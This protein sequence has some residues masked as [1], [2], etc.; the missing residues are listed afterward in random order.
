MKKQEP[1]SD[2]LKDKQSGCGRVFAGLFGLTFMVMG[3]C[4]FYFN[5]LKPYLQKRQSINWPTAE[6]TILEADKETHSGEDSDSY[7]VDFQYTFKVDGQAYSGRRYSFADSNGSLS[8]AERQIATFPVGST[9]KCF[10]NPQDPND[11]VLDRENKDQ[12]WAPFTLPFIFVG[13]GSL[14]LFFVIFLPRIGDTKSISGSIK[15][16]GNR[17]HKTTARFDDQPNGLLTTPLGGSKAVSDHPADQLDA[18]W[19]EPL[20]LKPAAS[21]WGQAFGIGV[22]ALIW[23][24]VIGFFIYLTAQGFNGFG[25]F[26]V[27]AFVFLIPFVLIGLLTFSGFVASVMSIF[28]PTVGIAL[29]RGAVPLGGTVDVA[30]QVEGRFEKIKKLTIHVEASQYATY[31]R[32]TDTTTDVEVFERLLV[33]ESTDI[34]DVA[35]GSSSVTIP[36]DSMH[37]FDAKRN[38]IK[39]Q[40][41]VHGEIPWSPDI[42]ENYEFRVTPVKT[43]SRSA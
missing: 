29:S 2:D 9:R 1:I 19:N 32:G 42:N 7:S 5:G 21:R 17:K 3:L 41:S 40:V 20:K 35:F 31:Q 11:C 28:N 25:W 36:I 23:N 15:S 12:G 27:G 34:S 37:T 43:K 39:W 24:G 13:F 26:Q 22:F 4:V 8:E 33:T 6:C 18:E 38:Q 14:V 10:Y 30:W 16:S